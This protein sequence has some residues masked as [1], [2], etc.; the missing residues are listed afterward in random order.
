MPLTARMPSWSQ[1][2]GA[3]STSDPPLYFGVV[4]PALRIALMAPCSIGSTGALRHIALISNAE[5][6]HG[7]A[8]VSFDNYG[9]SFSRADQCTVR[10][11]DPC[12]RVAWQQPTARDGMSGPDRRSVRGYRARVRRR[13]DVVAFAS[14]FKHGSSAS[15]WRPRAMA[16]TTRA[17]VC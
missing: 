14:P 15:P 11:T 1:R 2:G 3:L 17:H 6:N 8:T 12:P 10:A 13:S 5:A 9:R 7:T 4:A 16:I